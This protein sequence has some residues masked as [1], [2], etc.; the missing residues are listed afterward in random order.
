MIL[1]FKMVLGVINA[2]QYRQ[3]VDLRG[4]NHCEGVF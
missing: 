4:Q 2:Y 3:S 1:I